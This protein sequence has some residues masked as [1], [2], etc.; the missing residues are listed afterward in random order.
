[1]NIKTETNPVTL[2]QE[3][4]TNTPELPE[5]GTGPLDTTFPLAKPPANTTSIKKKKFK[6]TFIQI[7]STDPDCDNKMLFLY[8]YM[9]GLMETYTSGSFRLTLNTALPYQ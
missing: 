9:R 8:N 6:E 7:L 3:T 2:K 1:M 4:T 5:R